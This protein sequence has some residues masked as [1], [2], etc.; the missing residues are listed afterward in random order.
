MPSAFLSDTTPVGTSAFRIAI[1][2]AGV[3]GRVLAQAL[4]DRVK[5]APGPPAVEIRVYDAKAFADVPVGDPR[6]LELWPNALAA[7]ETVNGKLPSGAVTTV[8]TEVIALGYAL[9]RYDF[10][11]MPGNLTTAI[12]TGA[13]SKRIQS[14]TRVLSPLQLHKAVTAG[15]EFKEEAD[16]SDTST[17][18]VHVHTGTNYTLLAA[19][20]VGSGPAAAVKLDFGTP[21]AD[22]SS[23]P[24]VHNVTV[25]AD[26][27]LAADGACSTVRQIARPHEASATTKLFKARPERT[28]RLVCLVGETRDDVNHE[29]TLPGSAYVTHGQDIRFGAW[30]SPETGSKKLRWLCFLPATD[31][32]ATDPVGSEDAYLKGF[33]SAL[34]QGYPSTS[35]VTFKK[36]WK[37]WRA[38]WADP[39]GGA[40]DAGTD[41]ARAATRSIWLKKRLLR[42]LEG[43]H[44]AARSAVENTLFDASSTTFALHVLA[45]AD[46]AY[47]G[48]YAQRVA[49]VGDA[50]HPILPDLGQGC[51]LAFEDVEALARRMA[52]HLWP[53]GALVN[54]TTGPK[55]VV[56]ELLDDWR[57][58]RHD[59]ASEIVNLTRLASE[60]AHLDTTPPMV[61]D[62]MTMAFA[63]PMMVPNLLRLVSYRPPE[64]IV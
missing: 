10:R 13:I 12:P 59:R 21:P 17:T 48:W 58:E 37:N 4:L 15:F 30:L 7:L 23:D 22:G 54:W 36:V 5:R 35:G 42:C 19:T 28:S 52:E 64:T 60:A 44:A 9:D 45:D 3:T 34:E 14:Q 38:G 16:H 6:A 18:H 8:M 26:L 27:V 29:F 31:L 50:A 2:G 47:G 39:A 43:F 41:P 63:G 55:D 53:H 25:Y 33:L 62:A 49:L 11:G 51:G 32:V 20:M 1:I 56:E 57:D 46:V 61:R 40:A 24:P